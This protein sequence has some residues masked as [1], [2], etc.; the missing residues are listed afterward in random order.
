MIDKMVGNIV[1]KKPDGRIGPLTG[2]DQFLS[3]LLG[4]EAKRIASNSP[5]ETY[6][7][8][9]PPGALMAN[10]VEVVLQFYFDKIESISLYALSDRSVSWDDWSE[11]REIERKELHDRW[12]V[13]HLGICQGKFPWG[14]LTSSYDAR[15]GMSSICLR[16]SHKGE[17]WKM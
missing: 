16:Y 12:L 14:E 2:K 13:N 10:K 8:E 3:S 7:V 15:V 4:R 5:F 9:V 6:Q 17:P 11:K 1:V